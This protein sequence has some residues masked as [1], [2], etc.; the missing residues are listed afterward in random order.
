MRGRK[1]SYLAAMALLA[2]PVAVAEAKVNGPE[3]KSKKC[4]KQI[5]VAFTVN[6]TF[7][8]WNKSDMTVTVDV[9][10]ANRHARRWLN[11]SNAPVFSTTDARVKFVGLA[12]NWE[13]VVPT[14]RVKVRG[15]LA[16]QKKS[17]GGE[18]TLKVKKIKV[19]RPNG[20]A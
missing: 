8:N 1:L 11:Q 14:D 20:D 2:A 4:E 18:I 12:D 9:R 15:K 13:A 10:R 19:K 5:R 6:G 7:A 3:G 17:C 16:K